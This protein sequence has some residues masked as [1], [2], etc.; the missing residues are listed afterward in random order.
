MSPLEEY[1]SIVLF[2]QRNP[3]LDTEICHFHHII[4]RSLGGCND[5]WNI[6]RLPVGM[7]YRCHRL[8]PLIYTTGTAHKKMMC[9]W[10]MISCMNKQFISEEDYVKAMTEFKNSQ[11]G[12]H[13]SEET[14]KKISESRKGYHCTVH[15]KLS[16]E[17]KKKI[18]ESKKGKRHPGYVNGKH[19]QWSDESKQKVTGKAKPWLKGRHHTEEARA[20]M[21]EAARKRNGPGPNKGRKF[22][23]EHRRKISESLRRRRVA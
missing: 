1:N 15:R 17:T 18:S 6:V 11:V 19:W 22:S 2:Y 4:P 23:E 14:K 20:K 7:H 12:S 3:P 13:H 16:E 8:L 9:A 10:H 21:K 5:E